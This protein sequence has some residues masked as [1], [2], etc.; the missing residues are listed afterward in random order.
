MGFRSATININ[1]LAEQLNMNIEDLTTAVRNSRSGGL[2]RLWAFEDKGDFGSGRVNVSSRKDQNSDYEQQFQDGFVS[3]FGD[4]YKKAKELNIPEKGVAII[5][6]SCDVKNN[7][8]AKNKKMYT[9]YYIYDFE[10]LDATESR[11]SAAAQKKPQ[12]KNPTSAPVVDDDDDLP[13]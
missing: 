4:A 7:Y 8:V 3:F 5:I 13:F 12:T 1:K 2:A 6:L 9:N 11:A 10:V